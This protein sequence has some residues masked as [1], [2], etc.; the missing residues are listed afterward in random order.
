MIKDLVATLSKASSNKQVDRD[1]PLD[2]VGL[3]SA[4]KADGTKVDVYGV[5]MKKAT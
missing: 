1:S 4:T 2:V 3:G 5:T